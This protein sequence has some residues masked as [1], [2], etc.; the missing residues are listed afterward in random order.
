MGAVSEHEVGNLLVRV[1]DFARQCGHAQKGR[2]GQT[3]T[4]DAETVGPI[5]P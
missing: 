4:V 5:V 2:G 1:K 3:D